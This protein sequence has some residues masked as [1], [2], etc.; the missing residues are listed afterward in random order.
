MKL[1]YK[2]IFGIFLFSL[3]FIFSN[4]SFAYTVSNCINSTHNPATTGPFVNTDCLTYRSNELYSFISLDRQ[5]LTGFSRAGNLYR[6]DLFSTV[7]QESEYY[8]LIDETN[9]IVISRFDES[10]SDGS[11]YFYIQ[12]SQSSEYAVFPIYVKNGLFYESLSEIPQESSSTVES[13]VGNLNFG[14]AIIIGILS[15][16]MITFIYNQMR[17]K[18][19]WLK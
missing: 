14:L 4:N 1:Q 16:F 12:A 19:P 7:T 17:A 5:N 18:K 15:L 2:F 9:F 11:Y 10:I 6:V 13:S 3:F 8:S